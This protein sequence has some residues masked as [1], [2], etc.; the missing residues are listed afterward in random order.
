MRIPFYLA[1]SVFLC[2]T[3]FAQ[4]ANYDTSKPAELLALEYKTGTT[5]LQTT[6]MMQAMKLNMG[7]QAIDQKMDMS[8]TLEMTAADAASGKQLKFSYTRMAMDMEMMGQKMGFDSDKPD[9]SGNPFAAAFKDII[10]AEF[11]ATLDEKNKI[12][13]IEGVEELQKK[14]GANPM[15]A[16]LTGNMLSEDNF[17]NLLN[18]WYADGFPKT[19]VKAGDTWPM[20][21]EMALPGVGKMNYKGTYKHLGH[22]KQDGHDCI[23]IEVDGKM[24]VETGQGG[25]AA[26]MGM[27]ISGGSQKGIML[28]DNKLGY[29]RG[30]D[31]KQNM[32]MSMP[33][34]AGGEKLEVPVSQDIKMSISTK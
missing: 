34:P 25:E 14:A 17:K 19:P 21:M 1:A 18:N 9:D 30:M 2:S 13:K 15:T 10:G 11:T 31:L 33:N 4:E 5:Y 12:T 29:F 32:N 3:H 26:A 23:A 22:V 27:E 7:G 28:W 6:N 24:S 8:N 20:D 16:Q